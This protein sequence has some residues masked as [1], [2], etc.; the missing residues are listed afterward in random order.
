MMDGWN[1]F[2]ASSILSVIMP[3]NQIEAGVTLFHYRLFLTELQNNQAQFAGI[4]G[5]GL[6]DITLI[7]P[8]SVRFYANQRI[9][10]AAPVNYPQATS[11]ELPI[12][13]RD[14][15]QLVAFSDLLGSGQ[16]HLISI[17]HNEV[18]C[19]PNLGQGLFGAPIQLSGFQQPQNS[20]DPKQLYLVDLDGSGTTDIIYLMSDHLIIYM[21]QSGNSFASPIT[22]P[23]PNSVWLMMIPANCGLQI[24]KA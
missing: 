3:N 2:S 20:F 1:G 9:S 23:L 10:F 16:Q 13:G 17:R 6:A 4:T 15:R 5:A 19:W 24:S 18:T 12:I 14:E 7:G 11:V 8:K 22:I 21:N